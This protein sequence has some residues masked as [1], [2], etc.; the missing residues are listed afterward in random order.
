MGWLELIYRLTP[1]PTRGNSIKCGAECSGYGREEARPF[2]ADRRLSIKIDDEIFTRRHYRQRLK[3]TKRNCE[4]LERSIIEISGSKKKRPKA[5]EN[6]LRS[7][8]R[9]IVISNNFS[10]KNVARSRKNIRRE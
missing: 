7:T 5:N 6:R 10:L 1:R 3:Y 4:S 8:R 9:E 2:K